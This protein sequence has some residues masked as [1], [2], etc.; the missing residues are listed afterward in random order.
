M[1][2]GILLLQSNAFSQVTLRNK[3]A[4]M[5]VVGF[6]GT[7]VTDTLATDLSKRNLGGV[8]LMGGNIQTPL[9]LN[10]LSAKIKQIASTTPFIAT[11]EEGGKVAR[12]NSFNG[13]EET[14]T[15]FQLGS[16]FNSE[17]TTRKTGA[18]I[19]GWLSSSGINIDFA[20]VADLNVNPQSPAIG[21]YQRSFSADPAIVKKHVSFFVEELHKK[22][23]LAA[24]KHFP[25]H[26]SSLQ[27]SH[28]GFTDIS[29]TW[30]DL[31]LSPYKQLFA[32]GY[33]DIVMVGHLFNAKLD[34]LYP[35]SLSNSVLTGLLRQQLGF[36]G[37]IVTDDM[38]MKAI[39]SNYSFDKSVELA[40][41]AGNDLL[42]YVGGIRNGSSILPQIIDI[43]VGKIGEGKISEN[44]INESYER[45]IALKQKIQFLSAV[46]S[47]KVPKQVPT[48]LGLEN[49]PN[50]FNPNTNIVIKLN[51][52][53]F[54]SVKVYNITGQVV[55]N[56]GNS[57]MSA[58]EYKYVLDG[59]AL[60]SGIYLIRLE[61]SEGAIS[62][63]TA[64]L[65]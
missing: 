40:I 63:K 19:A 46:N 21:K 31:E 43:I 39:S 14:C 32:S 53:T 18:K 23:V 64:L 62:K 17:D 2:S 42:L 37:V 47:K 60:S 34:S 36:K 58:G 29:N 13:F 5:V 48:D 1:L 28:L 41:N 24:L 61:T 12:L 50:P 51:K 55:A 38:L 54:V 49:Y 26:G 25:G 30:S 52:G 4:Q 20:P 16:V 8:I 65:K 3:I 56:F 7:V 45:I 11:D 15:A 33:S 44:R 6:D 22:N 35:A 10:S 9:Q 57:Y 59:S 27:D